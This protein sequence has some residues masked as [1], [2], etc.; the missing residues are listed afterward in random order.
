MAQ[1]GF[2]LPPNVHPYTS[3][4]YPHPAK[5]EPYE[6]YV[7]HAMIE[8]QGDEREFTRAL[9]GICEACILQHTNEIS[10]PKSSLIASY[11]H[12]VNTDTPF[13]SIT[14][15]NTTATDLL[16]KALELK[17][18]ATSAKKYGFDAL[19][20]KSKNNNEEEKER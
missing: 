18:G 10:F 5:D 1:E 7:D 8:W 2:L 14:V 3:R 9:L 19:E 20:T 11:A 4:W 12:Y 13:P 6:E 16:E 17:F 15:S